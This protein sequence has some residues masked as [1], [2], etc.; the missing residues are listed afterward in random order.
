MHNIP[1]VS[2]IN[3]NKHVGS[4]YETLCLNFSSYH[5]VI[6]STLTLNNVFQMFWDK[7]FYLVF[8]KRKY[9]S[10]FPSFLYC[11][12]GSVYSGVVF[13]RRLCGVSI[14]R[15]YFSLVIEWVVNKRTCFYDLLYHQTIPKSL[16]SAGKAWRMHYEHVARESKS[17]KSSSMERVTMAD[18]FV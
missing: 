18:R 2:M 9:A 7:Y 12:A 16:I 5:A 1:S 13:C 3:F 15:R 14:I 6:I 11:F 4:L 10:S 17:V 8:W